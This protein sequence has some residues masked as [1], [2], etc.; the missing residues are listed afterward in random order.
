[1]LLESWQT[2]NCFAYTV[3]LKLRDGEVHGSVSFE[4]GANGRNPAWQVLRVAFLF[5]V[6]GNVLS[7]DLSP[8]KPVLVEG[9][10]DRVR[11]RLVPL[12][13]GGMVP[14]RDF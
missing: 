11:S 13:A 10:W 6:L 9:A 7:R 12:S 4:E 1:M 5:P 3:E 2:Q 8:L 14:I